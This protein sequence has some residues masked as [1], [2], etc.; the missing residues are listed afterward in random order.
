MRIKKVSEN[1]D[2]HTLQLE[3]L[4]PDRTLISGAVVAQHG[5]FKEEPEGDE[6]V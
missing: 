1:S 2:I 5:G 4:G 3:L 6:K